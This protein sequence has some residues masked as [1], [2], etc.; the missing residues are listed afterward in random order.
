VWHGTWE[1]GVMREHWTKATGTGVG[2]EHVVIWWVEWR[3]LDERMEWVVLD[4]RMEWLVL[5]ERME[6]LFLNEGV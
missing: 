3:F 4:E 5:N 1:G 2:E 6:W